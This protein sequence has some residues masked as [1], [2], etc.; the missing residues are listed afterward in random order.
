VTRHF[1]YWSQDNRAALRDVASTY[2][3]SIKFYGATKSA[4]FVMKEK[5]KFAERWPERDYKF[6]PN[7]T[8]SYCVTSTECSVEGVVEWR[9]HSSG[10]NASSTGKAEISFDLK[11]VG[12]SFVITNENGRVISNTNTNEQSNKK[13]IFSDCAECDETPREV[14]SPNRLIEF[15]L[16]NEDANDKE[17]ISECMREQGISKG[18]EHLLFSVSKID[19]NDDGLQDYFVRPSNRNFCFT[20]Y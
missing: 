2:A 7:V 12:D 4:S 9:T 1:G 10:R 13:E 16:K 5:K 11:V 3:A 6:F 19:L 14:N 8:V 18:Q 17:G 20:Y 15:V